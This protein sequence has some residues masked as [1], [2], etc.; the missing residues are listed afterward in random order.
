[1]RAFLLWDDHQRILTRQRS[2]CNKLPFLTQFNLGAKKE[3]YLY[4]FWRRAPKIIQILYSSPETEIRPI[5]IYGISTGTGPGIK[6]HP[7]N[8]YK[9][10]KVLLRPCIKMPGSGGYG[11]GGRSTQFPEPAMIE[12]FGLATRAHIWLAPAGRLAT[13]YSWKGRGPPYR[14]HGPDP[15]DPAFCS[16]T[17]S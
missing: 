6:Q 4:N 13:V 1:M 2:G 12:W 16:L 14:I 11:L 15:G 9:I 17:V 7:S 3:C 5:G 8:S 10:G